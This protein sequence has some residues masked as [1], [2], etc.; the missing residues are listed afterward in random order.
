MDIDTNKFLQ[1]ASFFIKDLAMFGTW[2]TQE[3]VNNLEKWN[4]TYIVNLVVDGEPK[5]V[6]YK[7]TKTVIKFPIPDRS[8]PPDAVLFSE[9]VIFLSKQLDLGEKI[10]IHC[11]GGHG[12][13]GTLVASILGYKY[14]LSPNDAMNLTSEFHSKRKQMDTRWRILGAP[15]TYEQKNFVVNL[16]KEHKICDTSPFYNTTINKEPH[17]KI[18]LKKT[19][20][21]NI[22]GPNA[23]D[24]L[25]L[26]WKLL[27]NY[28][29]HT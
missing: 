8:I 28:K 18:F 27:D 24:L 23:E 7:T 13:A 10:Y 19:N 9:L 3:F 12:R 5:I 15:Q 29:I 25:R 16:F 20:L 4:V 26:K 1:T 22:T 11:K 21:G 17:L 6:P 2:P 14:S